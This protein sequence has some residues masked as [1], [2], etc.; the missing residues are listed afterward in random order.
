M[1]YFRKSL[2]GWRVEVER[3]GKRSSATFPTKAAAANWAAHEESAI[4]KAKGAAFPLETLTSAMH[5]YVE[6]VSVNKKGAHFEKL[7]LLSLERN[8]PQL[9]G[10]VISEITSTHLSK[11]R[12]K[13]L[14]EVTPGSVQREINLLSNVFSIAR[15]E[16]HWHDGNPFKGVRQPGDNP[17]RTRRVDPGEVRRI[18]RWL[19]YK[20]GK[21]TTKYQQVAFAFLVS[22]RTGMRA[23]EVLT[24]DRSR[25]DL[26][27]KVA[28]VPHKMQ[29]LTGKEREIP[30]PRAAVRLLKA[31][32]AKGSI[33]TIS[34]ASLDVLFRRA[35]DAL[36]IEG[37]HFHDARAEALTR[38]A[39]KVDVMTL[40]RIS[41]H[42]DLNLLLN[43]YYRESARDI[44]ARM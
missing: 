30:L 19:G 14:K 28:T 16:W 37:L 40:A 21:I 5:K 12:D 32:P 26:A 33:F 11:W 22:L 7:R 43:T 13:R 24:L 20:T 6:E 2:K 25:V 23:G 4:L 36:L 41:G 18:C 9:A 1:A 38:L 27:R 15:D 10:M 3:N 31:L 44:A 35:R 34:S 8:F 42:K 39:R 29:H 17:A